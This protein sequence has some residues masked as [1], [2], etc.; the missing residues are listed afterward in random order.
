MLTPPPA[1]CVGFC[2][3]PSRRRL[4][5]GAAAA[6]LGSAG[7]CTHNRV[8]WPQPTPLCCEAAVPAVR[9]CRHQDDSNLIIIAEWEGRIDLQCEQIELT[10]PVSTF[11]AHHN[12]TQQCQQINPHVRP[13]LFLLNSTVRRNPKAV[14][15]W[16]AAGTEW[17]GVRTAVDGA[18]RC[19]SSLDWRGPPVVRGTSGTYSGST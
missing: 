19:V 18:D 15:W 6:A 4:L 8:Y 11:T 17:C 12:H 13:Q 1:A 14:F 3:N 7:T 9:R 10:T 16:S 2:S 5:L